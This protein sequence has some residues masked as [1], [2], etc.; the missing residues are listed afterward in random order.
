LP[1]IVLSVLLFIGI[2]HGLSKLIAHTLRRLFPDNEAKPNPGGPIKPIR[3]SAQDWS[4][5]A[6]RAPRVTIVTNDSSPPQ[7]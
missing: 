1:A 4:A 2:Y 7:A 3:V 5:D 6:N